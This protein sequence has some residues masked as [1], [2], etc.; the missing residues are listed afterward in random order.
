MRRKNKQ[1]KPKVSKMNK[2]KQTMLHQAPSG[3][4]ITLCPVCT[5]FPVTFLFREN[6]FITRAASCYLLSALCTLTVYT[7]GVISHVPGAL[8]RIYVFFLIVALL[9][10]LV[11]LPSSGEASVLQDFFSLAMSLFLRY[12]F[13]SKWVFT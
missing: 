5:K 10:W 3:T 12:C 8:V 1:K 9:Y 11:S 2:K 7:E 6:L 4:F 13:G